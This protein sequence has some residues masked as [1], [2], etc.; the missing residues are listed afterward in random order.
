M[1]EIEPSIDVSLPTINVIEVGWYV[2]DY[3]LFYK[4]LD[5]GDTGEIWVSEESQDDTYPIHDTYT[6]FLTG[7]ENGVTI[8]KE[9]I[10]TYLERLEEW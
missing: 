5:G 2:G 1:F 4:S 6:F 3:I 7:S 9:D 8:Q 10:K